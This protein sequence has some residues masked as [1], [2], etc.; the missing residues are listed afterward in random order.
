MFLCDITYTPNEIGRE[1]R[2]TW[3][4]EVWNDKTFCVHSLHAQRFDFVREDKGGYLSAQELAAVIFFRYD[5]KEIFAGS[6]EQ[7]FPGCVVGRGVQIKRSNLS[8]P[9][10][11]STQRKNEKW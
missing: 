2:R 7:L 11:S 3:C 1:K 9:K 6:A 4:S 5:F 8:S 10:N